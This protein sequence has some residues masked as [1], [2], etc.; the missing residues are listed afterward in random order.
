MASCFDPA[1]AAEQRYVGRAGIDTQSA[2]L[3]R[4]VP[5]VL[6]GVAA[7]LAFAAATLRGTFWTLLWPSAA[8]A[9]AA[10]AYLTRRP[11]LLG[12]RG[13]GFPLGSHIVMLPYLGL[14]S[15]L[16]HALRVLE[17]RPAWQRATPDLFIGR[18]L[19][20]SEFPSG[21]SSVVDLTSELSGLVP[22]GDSTRYLALPILDGEAP[23]PAAL[24][25]A[26]QA[27]ASLPKPIYLHC[28]QGHG[29]TGLV[30][31]GLFLATGLASDPVDAVDRLRTTRPGIR[32]NRQQWRALRDTHMLIPTPRDAA[33]QAVQAVEA[34]GRASS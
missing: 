11:T 23:P 14:C 16:W 17:R 7:E 3:R 9:I 10:L 27:I 26:L 29:R 25:S 15:L 30:A 20:P 13:R 1:A 19:L 6:T 8:F 33:Q 31:A 2:A 21:I 4:F 5:I 24:A 22:P 12:K 34:D 32:L 28:A 18:R